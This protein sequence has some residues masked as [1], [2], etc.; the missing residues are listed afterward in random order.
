MDREWI[1]ADREAVS[2]FY[3]RLTGPIQELCR[4]LDRIVY[5]EVPTAQ[6]GV[7]WAVPFYFTLV[8][9]LC[10]VSPARHH[11]TFGVARGMEVEDP[12]GMLTGTG[13]SPIRK[14]ILKANVVFPEDAI[15]GWLRAANSLP[16]EE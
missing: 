5:Q 14:A 2:R 6:V 13:R 3:D 4:R 8:G 11:V 12:T 16:P 10:Y 1:V 9:P 7:K 15:R